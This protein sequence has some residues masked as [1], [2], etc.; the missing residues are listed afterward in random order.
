VGD[1][2]YGGRRRQIAGQVPQLNALLQAFRRQ[3]LHAQRLRFVDPAG[4]RE[5]EFEA[6]LPADFQSLLRALRADLRACLHAVATR[7]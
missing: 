7:R 2:M 4:E 5:L 3:A 1:P 6:P